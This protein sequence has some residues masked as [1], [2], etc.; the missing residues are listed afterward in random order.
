MYAA[1]KDHFNDSLNMSFSQG[2][3][4]FDIKKELVKMKPLI[5]ALLDKCRFAINHEFVSCETRLNEG[6]IIDILPPS[7]GG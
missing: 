6:D 3:T 1:L 7:S 2:A 4:I 5:A